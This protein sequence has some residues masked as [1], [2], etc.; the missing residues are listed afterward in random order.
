M[1]A[2][3]KLAFRKLHFVF[4]LSDWLQALGKF[5]SVSKVQ[6]FKDPDLLLILDRLDGWEEPF[7]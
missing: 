5:Y 1:F 6:S 2:N 3:A 4:L 7:S